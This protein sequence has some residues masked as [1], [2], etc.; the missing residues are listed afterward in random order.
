MGGVW[1]GGD[2]EAFA[3]EIKGAVIHIGLFGGSREVFEGPLSKDFTVTWDATLTEAVRR[4]AG[5]ARPGEAVLLSPATSSFDQYK[6][7]GQRGDDFKRAVMELKGL[8]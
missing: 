7:Y 2:V 5:L 6:N 8:E 1:K 3:R 4:Q